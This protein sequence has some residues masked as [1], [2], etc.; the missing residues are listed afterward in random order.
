MTAE[1]KH[2]ILTEEGPVSRAVTPYET[3]CEASEEVP[4][5]A[6]TL[7][8]VPGHGIN[9]GHDADP[10]IVG[11]L[12]DKLVSACTDLEDTLLRLGRAGAQHDCPS[13]LPGLGGWCRCRCHGSTRTVSLSVS[14]RGSDLGLRHPGR[15]GSRAFGR[16]I[17]RGL[18]F[19]GLTCR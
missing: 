7:K 15:L 17:Q 4:L 8:V 3:A 2:P 1:P 9:S 14:G 6:D 12:S 5:I 16:R 13:R 11:W 19:F 10:A 18:W